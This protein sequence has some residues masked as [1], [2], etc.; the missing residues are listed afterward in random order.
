MNFKEGMSVKIKGV[1]FSYRV[2]V[3]SAAME[4]MV[5]KTYSIHANQCLLDKGWVEIEGWYWDC[6]DL[7]QVINTKKFSQEDKTTWKSLFE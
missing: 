3:Q 2:C 7:E 1:S 5:G 6:R 4:K